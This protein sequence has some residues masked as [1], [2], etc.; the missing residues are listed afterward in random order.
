MMKLRSQNQVPGE[1]IAFLAS[2][3]AWSA[4]FVAV[5]LLVEFACGVELL[6]GAVRPLTLILMLPTL[7]VIGYAGWRG[8]LAKQQA[9]QTE[10]DPGSEEDPAQTQYFSGQVGI[11]LSG[12]FVLLTLAVGATAL[13]LQP[14]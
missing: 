2:P 7:V 12:L 4:Y 14:C 1:T 6:V 13:V 8:R 11:W 10:A 5:Y 9:A 3:V